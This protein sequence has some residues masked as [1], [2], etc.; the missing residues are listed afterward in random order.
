M[1]SIEKRGKNTWRLTVETGTKTV[2]TKDGQTKVIR[3][4]ERKPIKVEDEA[5]LRTT[6]KLREYL[7]SEW[8][9]FK[10]EVDSGTYITP[11][12]ATFKEF[13]DQHWRPKY[14]SDP[15]NLAPSSLVIYEQH[16]KTHIMPHFGHLRMD[17][18][19]NSHISDFK[20]YL[21]SPEA[22]KDGK[23][24]PLWN[25]T[26]RYI[27]RVLRNVFVYAHEERKIIPA[28]PCTGVRWPKKPETKIK[29]YEEEEVIQIIDAL[30]RQPTI[31]RL[32]ILGTFL[33][34]FRRGEVVALEISDCNFG[35]N[36]IRIDENIPMKIN[37][38]HL[39]KRPKTNSSMRTVKMPSW[40]MRE[41]E[42]YTK[43]WKKQMWSVGTKWKG[44]D[45]QFL[46]HRGYGIPY[47]P[48]TPTRW[49]REF[50]AKNGFRHLN[51]H[52]LRHTSATYLL[53]K[54]ATTKSVQE[55]LGH[56]S[57][58]TTAGYLHVTKK[59]EERVAQEFD[60]FDRH[61]TKP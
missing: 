60:R 7:E 48:N 22:R 41:L 4:R 12:K 45:R 37:R 31:W 24:G 43:D 35:D 51:L 50:L 21:R 26:Q 36:T 27:L 46:F 1:P 17:E 5:L 61:N 3:D 15:E 53:E 57:E 14:A 56:S 52:G 42:A 8:H 59:M 10:A 13:V 38:Q 16:L 58:R 34:G 40:Y 2:V 32:L 18:I 11:E 55:R 25:G 6:K 49:W 23:E 28:N 54:G 44:G 39:I 9:K 29:V 33:G 19:K 30:Y 20:V 47:H